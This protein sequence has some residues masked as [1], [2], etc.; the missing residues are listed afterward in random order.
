MC[1][2][3]ESFGVFLEVLTLRVLSANAD[4]DLHQDALTAPPPRVWACV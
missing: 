2:Y 4:R 3:G 1:V